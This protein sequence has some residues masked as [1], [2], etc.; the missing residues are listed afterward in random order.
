[1]EDLKEY[2]NYLKYNKNYSDNTLVNYE[3]DIEEYLNF[4]NR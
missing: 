3:E 2:L 1:M 4:L